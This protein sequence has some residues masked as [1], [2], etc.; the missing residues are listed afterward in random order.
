MRQI[1]ALEAWQQR[2]QDFE[3]RFQLGDSMKLRHM[4]GRLFGK[5]KPPSLNEYRDHLLAGHAIGA[6][7]L[8]DSVSIPSEQERLA[9]SDHD[10]NLAAKPSEFG[11]QTTLARRAVSKIL[12][13]LQ[14]GKVPIVERMGGPNNST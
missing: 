8:Q 14:A 13:D 4:I 6:L 1:H 10:D 7:P 11:L 3:R 2:D 12:M 9:A 5:F